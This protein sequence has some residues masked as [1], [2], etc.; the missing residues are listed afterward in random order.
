MFTYTF[1]FNTFILFTYFDSK[2]KANDIFIHFV[3]PRVVFEFLF[4]KIRTNIILLYTWRFS[5]NIYIHMS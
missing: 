4:E 3:S 1:H 5:C 2:I